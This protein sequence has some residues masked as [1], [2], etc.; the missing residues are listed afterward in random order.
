M[1]RGEKFWNPYNQVPVSTEPIQRSAPLYHHRFQGLAG[2]LHVT[3][4]GLT[5]LL[6]NDGRHSFVSSKRTNKPFIPGTSL[7]GMVRS[8]AEL[9]SNSAVPIDR[10]LVDPDHRVNRG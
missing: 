5:P 7:K 9:V 4:E 1:P 3:L 10:S 2:R 8:L 6:I